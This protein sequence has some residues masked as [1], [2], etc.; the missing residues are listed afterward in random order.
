MRQHYLTTCILHALT[1]MYDQRIVSVRMN[2]A[3]DSYGIHVFG[4]HI[5]M[6]YVVP[7]TD[8]YS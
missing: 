5:P 3:N 4:I 2:V 7:Q 6:S 1:A 8:F